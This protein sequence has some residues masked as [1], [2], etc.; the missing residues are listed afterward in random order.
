MYWLYL[1]DEKC[2]D[3][4]IQSRIL[5]IYWLPPRMDGRDYVCLRKAGSQERIIM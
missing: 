2:I 4:I 5:M 1:N 3:L